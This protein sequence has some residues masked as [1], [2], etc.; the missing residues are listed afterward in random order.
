MRTSEFMSE[1]WPHPAPGLLNSLSLLPM[2]FVAEEGGE[3][4]DY[5]GSPYRV[6][7]QAANIRERK[8]MLRSEPRPRPAPAERPPVKM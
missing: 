3:G 2:C 1:P 8:R 6:Q 7:R 4:E 5:Y